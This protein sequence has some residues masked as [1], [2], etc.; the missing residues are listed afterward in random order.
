[1]SWRCLP[2]SSVP[3]FRFALSAMRE[4]VD[5]RAADARSRHRVIRQVARSHTR[6]SCRAYQGV[7]FPAADEVLLDERLECVEVGVADGL[8]RLHRKASRE[9]GKPT[10]DLL[11]L[12]IEQV[13]AP[14]DR[15]AQR[16]LPVRCVAGAAG[17][18]RQ[19]PVEPGQQLVRLEER[20]PGRRELDRE[21]QPVQSSADLGY[22]F[23]RAEPGRDRLRALNEER[24]RRRVRKAARPGTLLGIDV[25]G[26]ATRDQHLRVR[27]AR[28]ERRNAGAASTT[29]SKLSRR[30]SRRLL[31]T[32]AIRAPSART[33]LSIARSTRA[34]SRIAWSGTQKTPSGNAR[35]SRR[36]AEARDAS[37][38]AARPDQRT[39]AM[40]RR[41]APP[42]RARAP[43]RR[44]ASA[45]S[46]GS[47]DRGSSAAGTRPRRA[48]TGAAAR[49]DP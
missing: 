26:R 32:W 45:G 24:S 38:A 36:R 35:P 22:R 19:P 14:R 48:G 49:S 30:M 7:R 27:R 28:E 21:R 13:V 31:A 20:D 44:A 33:E 17:E 6:G 3:A 18:Q 29:C 10:E 1:M 11:L 23:R 46:A 4:E 16:S 9:D 2:T 37:S 5:W 39:Q 41:S 8:R 40:P 47:S 34:G 42:P 15:G 43:G 25:Q 12:R